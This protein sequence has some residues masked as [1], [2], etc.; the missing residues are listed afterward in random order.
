MESLS[1]RVDYLQLCKNM[2]ITTGMVKLDQHEHAFEFFGSKKCS[3]LEC[4]SVKNEIEI[5]GNFKCIEN[6][7]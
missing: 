4:V 5:K 2:K 6:C 1:K 7:G 3:N